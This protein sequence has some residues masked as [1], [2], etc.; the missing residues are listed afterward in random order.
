MST[1]TVVF[2]SLGLI[3]QTLITDYLTVA[4]INPELSKLIQVFSSIVVLVFS[5]L[6]SKNNYSARADKL[7]S[8]ASL[9]TEL[10]QEIRPYVQTGN[11]TLYKDYSAKYNVI[12]RQYQSHAVDDFSIDNIVSKL[13]MKEYY[14]PSIGSRVMAH[15][16][17]RLFYFIEFSPY[18]LL[19]LVQY[20]F[21]LSPLFL[22]PIP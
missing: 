13:S 2:L 21:I 20:Y 1:V 17:Y 12:L 18:F 15:T 22:I 5:I 8:C 4:N 14:Y 9:L 7:Y 11:E 16:K 3:L 10:K 6:I 19:V